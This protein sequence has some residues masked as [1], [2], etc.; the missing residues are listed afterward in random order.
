MS[1]FVQSTEAI[2]SALLLWDIKHT[3]TSIEAVYETK[4]FPSSAYDNDSP[5]YFDLIPQQHGELIDLE[6]HTQWHVKNGAQNL[7]NN[8]N[9]SFVN[10]IANSFWSYLDIQIGDYGNIMQS[11]NLSYAFQTFFENCLNHESSR[12]DYL[13]TTELFKMDV[14]TTKT[15]CESVNFFTHPANETITENTAAISRAGLI[16]ESKRVKTISKLHCPIFRHSKALP[17]RSR[18]RI[19][20]NKNKDAFLLLAAK[21]SNFKI[22]IDEVYLKCKYLKPTEYVL[23]CQEEKLVK[24][25]ALYDIDYPEITIRNVGIGE[26]NLTFNRLFT[27]KLPKIAFFC[28]QRTSDLSGSYDSN[29]FVFAKFKSFQLYVDNVQYFTESLTMD[30]RTDGRD[31]LIQL[32]KSIGKEYKGDCLVNSSNLGI[33]QI[34]AVPLTNDRTHLKHLNLQKHSDIRVEL[35][36]GYNAEHSHSLIIYSIYDKLIQIDGERNISIVE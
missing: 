3:N 25:P 1:K 33:L 21:D 20:F 32:Y 16:S 22:N 23:K 6:I 11:M 26:R 35:D 36:L 18:I 5:I 19:T 27:K 28:I 29:P 17:T 15:A 30:N 13:Y 4:V 34:V 24:Q 10:N 9:C 2:D 8:A 14:G 7:A 12:S 31:T